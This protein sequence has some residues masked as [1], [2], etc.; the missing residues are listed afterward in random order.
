MKKA[1][2]LSV[3][4]AMLS[5]VIFTATGPKAAARSDTKSNGAPAQIAPMAC[6]APPPGLVRWYRAENNGVD[7]SGTSDG[8]LLNGTGFTLGQVGQGFDF[9]GVDD[10]FT[11]P[12]SPALA[13]GTNSFTIETWARADSTN[14]YSALFTK[15]VDA[16]PFDGFNFYRGP[17]GI[18]GSDIKS[19][20][21]VT[22]SSD[23]A[24]QL[25]QWHH[26][27]LVIDRASNTAKMYVN[28]VLQASQP[29]LAGIGSLT[30][31]EPLRLGRVVNSVANPNPA[32]AFDGSLDEFSIYD[33][34]LSTTDIQDIY[35]AG[36]NGKCVPPAAF[37]CIPTPAGINSWFPANDSTSDIQ[38]GNT[39]GSLIGDAAYTN[40]AKVGR[41][42]T[43]DGSGDYFSVPDAPEQK[44]IDQLTVEGW[45]EFDTLP[46][47]A[48]HLIAKPLRNSNDDSY[49]MW[50]SEGDIRIGYR[51]SGGGFL[52]YDTGF[53]PQTG[54]YYHIAF[55]LDTTD[56]GPTA[57][58]MKLFVNGIQVFSGAAGLPVYYNGIDDALPPHP[59]LIGADLEG[60]NPQYSLDGRADEVS[61]YGRALGAAEIQ[62]IY[63]AGTAGKCS[64]ACTTPAPGMVAWYPSEGSALDVRGGNNGTL[65]NGTAFAPGKVGQAFSFDGSNDYI[66]IPKS[67]ALNFGTGDFSVEFWAKFNNAG[68]LGGLIS[69]DNFGAAGDYNGWLFNNDFSSN[70]VG[71]LTRK[72]SVGTA[73]ARIPVSNFSNGVWYHLAGV[74]TGR[75]INFYVNGTLVSSG[76]ETSAIDVSNP[77]ELRIGSLS[78]GAPQNFSGLIDEVA[79]YN[80]ALS[81][82]EVAGAAGAAKCKPTAVA[83]PA[84]QTAWWA[85]DGDALDATGN[86]NNGALQNGATFAVNKVGQGFGFD[87]ANSVV[88]VPDSPGLD[89]LSA[90][91]IETWIYLDNV[92]GATIISKGRVDTNQASYTLSLYLGDLRA[93]LY[94]GN[95]SPTDYVPIRI[96]ATPLVGR[97]SHVALTWD[98]SNFRM[99]VNGVL[100]GSNI[101]SFTRDDTNIPVTFGKA[102]PESPSFSGRL[103]EISFYDRPLSV[104]EIQ[105]IFTAGIAGK[106]KSAGTPTGLAGKSPGKNTPAPEAVNTT[107]GDVTVAFQNVAI[108]GTTQQI[109]LDLAVLPALPGVT[110]LGLTY[111]VSTTAVYSGG[112]A[113]C[114]N[115]PSLAAT[116]ATNLRVYHLEAG[117][118]V[119]R[120][121]PGATH[122][123]LCTTS[124][125]SL[126][127]FAITNAAPTAASVGV[128]GRVATPGGRGI[129]NAIVKLM[130]PSGEARTVQTGGFG[131][132][133]FD[134]VDAGRNYIVTVSAK[135]FRFGDATRVIFAGDEI[136]GLDFI[137]IE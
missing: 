16:N 85:G 87:G 14:N 98:G 68:G 99:F 100:M 67:P 34:A 9:D 19:G 73:H 60:N 38:S 31:S 7:S 20:N 30:N 39:N 53:V 15:R 125:P 128:S 5:L 135:R 17:D 103:D 105:S 8:T 113:L 44:P 129:A 26:L 84:G 93:D 13:F 91:A 116:A 118:W 120:T 107:F 11:A 88:T 36:A 97:W 70:G 108:A 71:W 58:T 33:R 76:T 24:M 10:M 72:A 96:P 83:P 37:S 12:D 41:A 134:N 137:S 56:A 119:N 28:G 4:T 43:F 32:Q 54:V 74:R 61:L 21:V 57:N 115:V 81:P 75:T 82:V 42:F 3:L 101:Y 52:Y 27:A 131:Y 112:V 35:N 80:R 1:L 50:F 123:A 46:G 78:Q 55:V 126:S 47:N 29:S 95:G 79:L 23:A 62:S 64:G 51:Q 106:L 109:P 6:I 63:G 89:M 94:K 92:N 127:P 18:L 104:A 121:A 122:S 114:F 48:P 69:G 22:V 40:N 66:S 124:L 110:S 133:S 2:Y 90:G 25:G 59:L 130:D 45:F 77:Y 136:T 102:Y 65:Q 117:T 49:A 111:D 86:G 132:Y